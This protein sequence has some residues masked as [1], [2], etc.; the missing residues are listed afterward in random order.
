MTVL[1]DGFVRVD[2]I[3]AFENLTAPDKKGKYGGK[4]LVSKSA[5][6]DIAELN[7]IQQAAATTGGVPYFPKFTPG[8][9]HYDGDVYRDSK[10]QPVPSFAGYWLLNA[11]SGFP[12][13]LLDEQNGELN[14]TA[15]P[16]HKA[17]I[18]SG[19]GCQVVVNAFGYPSKDGG[20]PG[21]A[22]GCAAVKITDTTKPRIAE[23]GSG[24]LTAVSAAA[25]FGGAVPAQQVQHQ[26]VP[27]PG[28]VVTPAPTFMQPPAPT[29]TRQLVATGAH[30][31]QALRDA[32]WTD[33]AMVQA[34]HAVW[35]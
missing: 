27:G 13:V 25:M 7:S 31:V 29:P 15:I 9:P 17:K 28:A 4:W 20:Q 3:L 8:N 2:A 16:A 14:P 34:G 26:A 11:R 30:T 6:Q 1:A 23:G 19:V 35:Q 33:D 5:V 18:Y 12:I 22:F 24:G 21:V 32:G 10:G